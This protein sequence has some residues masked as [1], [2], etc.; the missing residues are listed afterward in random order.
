MMKLD[1]LDHLVLTV[2]DIDTTA[3]FYQ[4]VLGMSTV[5]FGEGRKALA[6]GTQKIN[7]HQQ[8]REFEPKAERPTPGSAD[9]CFLTSVPLDAVAAHFAACNIAIL[10]GPIRRTGATGPIM[11]LYIRDPD[12]N[13]IE[14]SNQ[15]KT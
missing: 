5:V 12:C 10:E 13:L 8:G 7:L 4:R 6:F 14:V 15:L 2:K 11:S 1:S 3:D 9:L